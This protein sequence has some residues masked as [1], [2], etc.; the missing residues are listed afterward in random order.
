M[1]I[2][3]PLC[4]SNSDKVFISN[5][6]LMHFVANICRKA[7]KCIDGKFA[8][9][10]IFAKRFCIVR[11]STGLIIFQKFKQKFRNRNV[12]F[13]AFAFRFS[14]NEFCLFQAIFCLNPLNRMLDGQNVFF[15]INVVPCQCTK[16]PDS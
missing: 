2:S 14:N 3:M 8:F 11:G 5:P 1:V 12:S 13:A 6:N 4:P 16:F 7:W 10:N 9:F 15:K